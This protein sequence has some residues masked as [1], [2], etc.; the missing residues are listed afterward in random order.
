MDLNTGEASR[1]GT[2]RKSPPQCRCI[3]IKARTKSDETFRICRMERETCAMARARFR[4]RAMRWTAIPIP[5][6]A[7]TAKGVAQ[8]PRSLSRGQALAI[9]RVE[10][11]GRC[12]PRTGKRSLIANIEPALAKAGVDNQPV[13]ACLSPLILQCSR[14]EVSCCGL[15]CAVLHGLGV[16]TRQMVPIL[17]SRHHRESAAQRRATERW[18]WLAAFAQGCPGKLFLQVE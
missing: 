1:S 14:C 7:A 6:S 5:S 3:H 12:R 16:R 17:F 2:A 18:P 8:I 10:E 11:Q 9:G 4:P 13:L 15:G